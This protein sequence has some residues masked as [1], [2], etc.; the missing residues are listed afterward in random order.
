MLT[1]MPA[2][3]LLHA[4]CAAIYAVAAVVILL[5]TRLGRTGLAL[6]AACVVTA[7]WALGVA[8]NGD[9]PFGGVPGWLEVA[10]SVAWYGFLLHLYGRTTAQ[11][12]QFGQ[13]FTT[14]GLV[15]VL[16]MGALPL[17]DMVGGSRDLSWWSLGIA[18]RLA[19]AV[20]NL[21]LIENVYLNTP[22]DLRWHINLPCVALGGLFLYDLVLYSDAVLFHRISPLLFEGRA[23]A[24]AL[25][26][27]LL[28]VSTA[29]TRRWGVHIQVSRT[30]AFHSA[31]LIVSGVFL[32]GLAATGE[33]FRH[34]SPGWGLVA[35]VTLVFGG[36]VIVA[37]LLTSASARS[38]LRRVLVNHF[39]RQRYDYRQE[40]MRCINTLS[41]PETYVGLQTRAIQAVAQVVDSPA[42]VLFVRSADATAFQWAGSWNLPAVA[43]ALSPADP[44]LAEFR[45]GNWVVRLADLPA[46]PDWAAELRRAWLAV[47]LN[48]VGRLIG[49]VVVAQPRAPFALDGEAYDLLRIVGREVA[50]HVAEQQAQ[51]VLTQSRQL[52]EYSKRF[53]FVIHDIKNV[54][55]QLSLLL[56]NAEMHWA[57]PEFQRDM[58][59]TVRASVGRISGMLAKLQARERGLGPAVIAPIER[60]KAL[61]AAGA[62]RHAGAAGAAARVAIG[63]D[64]DGQAAGVAMDGAAFDA[65]VEHLLDNAL[66]ASAG[67]GEVRI[68]IRHEGLSVV[69]DIID[70]GGGMT[71]E[72]IRDR[73]F[74]PFAS[75]KSGGHGIGAY[76]ARELLREAGGDLLVLSRPGAGTTMRLLLPAVGMRVENPA[77]MSA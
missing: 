37:V 60:L 36:M 64:D 61:A 16:L 18:I 63:L 53:A 1:D 48:H 52:H 75:T 5:R 2:L 41:A 10:R 57:N 29:R 62:R 66:E 59:G 69:I 9:D 15:A 27:P 68:R 46:L 45:D 11:R 24:T 7:A 26:A 72:F 74:Q 40:W 21:L 38:R 65:V 49:F 73:L 6:A 28:A 34:G 31:T 23:S 8:L 51:Q 33:I 3:V 20:C 42:G 25:V 44:L 67:A 12:A 19:L 35:Q 55:S 30:V 58:L 22:P 77:A 13:T 4:G 70:G 76:Q 32:L 56:S 17:I 50:S 47:P 39:Y 54:S 14:M 43:G 71:P